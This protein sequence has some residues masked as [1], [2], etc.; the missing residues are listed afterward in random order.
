MED[1]PFDEIIYPRE[2]ENVFSLIDFGQNNEISETE[3]ISATARYKKVA[4]FLKINLLEQDRLITI[5]ETKDACEH[6]RS[7]DNIAV[8]KSYVSLMDEKSVSGGSNE[9]LQGS[10]CNRFTPL[11]WICKRANNDE[12]SKDVES[13]E[14]SKYGATEQL[15]EEGSSRITEQNIVA[16]V[17]KL[18]VWSTDGLGP[19]NGRI[20]WQAGWVS[21][22]AP[23]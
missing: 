16:D 4:N 7:S 17:Q 23:P 6:L 1:T 10:I 18:T 3:F 5:R 9:S 19:R 14:V 20:T 15:R 13:K 11:N 21:S 12:E 8:S 22:Y 2:I